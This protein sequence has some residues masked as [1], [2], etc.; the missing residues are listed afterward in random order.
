MGEV[1]REAIRSMLWRAVTLAERSVLWSTIRGDLLWLAVHFNPKDPDW[2]IVIRGEIPGLLQR[3]EGTTRYWE[4]HPEE[5]PPRQRCLLKNN[6][7]LVKLLEEI[8]A[9]VC[10][11][12]PPEEECSKHEEDYP[13]PKEDPDDIEIERMVEREAERRDYWASYPE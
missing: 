7:E 12:A 13:P 3:V 8:F 4:T 1:E 9:K 10:E 5:L 6:R 2:L 11:L